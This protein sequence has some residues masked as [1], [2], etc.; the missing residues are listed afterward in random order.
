MGADDLWVLP[1][2]VLEPFIGATLAAG[3]SA[4]IGSSHAIASTPRLPGLNFGWNFSLSA[5][6]L[7]S[8]RQRDSPPETTARY[9]AGNWD[10]DEAPD[11]TAR[12]KAPEG[13]HLPI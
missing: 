10:L 6:P 1:T 5:R 12:R 3:R 8:A 7:R 11:R 13:G 2:P 4:P 9:S